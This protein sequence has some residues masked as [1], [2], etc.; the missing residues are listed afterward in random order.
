MKLGCDVIKD[1]LPLYVD[2]ICSEESRA[3]IDEHLQ[4]C[5]D[6]REELL[7]FSSHQVE[8]QLQEDAGQELKQFST[9]FKKR[10]KKVK[11]ALIALSCVAALSLVLFGGL[12]WNHLRMA[13]ENRIVDFMTEGSITV[14]KSYL[15]DINPS[16]LT[17]PEDGSY[18]LDIRAEGDLDNFTL[19]I[20]YD[21]G[22]NHENNHGS[23]WYA[24]IPLND[25]PSSINLTSGNYIVAL[26]LSEQ[27][28]NLFTCYYTV[29]I[30]SP[31]L[32][33]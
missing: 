25:A 8:S 7:R 31:E 18:S 33:K 26:V 21:Y 23:S 30:T 2:H 29:R 14:N 28:Q 27:D 20:R 9:S 5:T 3:L 13:E 16:V 10:K 19:L 32:G 17:I 1:L 4:S 22:K 11:I 12:Y 6:C 15:G 24:S